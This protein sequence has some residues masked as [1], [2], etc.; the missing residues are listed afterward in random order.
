MLFL[1]SPGLGPGAP[2]GGMVRSSANSAII[3]R[4]V[5]P[6]SGNSEVQR[7]GRTSVNR[8]FQQSS[9]CALGLTLLLA[10]Q[11]VD[12]PVTDAAVTDRPDIILIVIDTLRQDHLGIYGHFRDTSPHIDDLARRSV[13]YTRA[14]SQAPWTT[15]SIAA[16]LT[17]RYPTSLGITK[18]S[19]ALDEDLWLLP[20]ELSR[21]GYVTGAVVSHSFCSAEW[22]FDQGFEYFDETN[23]LG[24]AAVTSTGVTDRAI[25]FLE[26][27]SGEPVFLFVHYFD[28]HVSYV[29]HEEHRLG[30]T[31]SDYTGWVR[32]GM[33]FREIRQRRD[34]ITAAD[35]QELSRIYDSEIRHTDAQVGRLLQYLDGAGRLEPSLVILTA[36]HGEAFMEHGYFGHA[37][38]LH[39]SLVQVPL[40]IHY[41]GIPPQVVDDPVGLV[42]IY[43]TVTAVLGLPTPE[44]VEGTPLLD[45][46]TGQ[47]RAPEAVFSETDRFRPWRSVVLGNHKLIL[48]VKAGEVSLYD[49]ERDPGERHDLSASQP[50]RADALRQRIEAWRRLQQPPASPREAEIDP[51]ERRR[52][53]QLGYL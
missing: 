5:R 26:A 52:L 24:H 53:E 22:G 29:E 48:D 14:F 10:C 2:L 7:P 18:E 6:R 4:A 32:S 33:V 47:L 12:E 15:P 34:E 28:P 21:A 41:P 44:S 35:I 40:V 49:I 17:S 38:R 37:K 13:L 16:L 46:A 36:D 51:E 42:D 30:G 45:A 23:V 20:E 3:A 25:E 11:P 1:R 27:Y 43:P 19:S 31:P 8:V 50:E 39:N 9:L